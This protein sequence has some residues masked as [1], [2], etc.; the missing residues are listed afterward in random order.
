[1]EKP[2]EV[3]KIITLPTVDDKSV[4]VQLALSLLTEKLIT[5]LTRIKSIY[6]NL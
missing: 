3:E 2:I 1:M 4:R 6:P 5:E